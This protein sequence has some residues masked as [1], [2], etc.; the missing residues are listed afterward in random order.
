ME[1]SG[2]VQH[3]HE[4]F[5]YKLRKS[6]YGLKQASRAWHPKIDEKVLPS[7][8]VPRHTQEASK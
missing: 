1:P 3:G 8:F 5:V 6:L 7:S 2:Y 4:H